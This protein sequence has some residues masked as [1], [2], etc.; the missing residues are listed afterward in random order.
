MRK[1]RHHPAHGLVVRRDAEGEVCGLVLRWPPDGSGAFCASPI[2][3]KRA[4]AMSPSI[5]NWSILRTIASNLVIVST[6]SPR[7]IFTSRAASFM[8]ISFG[9][10][11]PFRRPTELPLWPGWNRECTGGR[12]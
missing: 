12:P 2:K 3:T 11:W 9:V 6:V 10:G 8:K 5:A 7:L 4:A 1:A